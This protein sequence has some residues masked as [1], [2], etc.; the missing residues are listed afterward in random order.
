LYNIPYVIFAGGLEQIGG[1]LVLLVAMASH[2]L[3]CVS[4]MADCLGVGACVMGRK[5]GAGQEKVTMQLA[6][7]KPGNER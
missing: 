4:M 1:V 6:E 2:T 3:L 5:G 7:E